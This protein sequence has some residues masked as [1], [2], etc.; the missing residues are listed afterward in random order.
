MTDK[1]KYEVTQADR[2]AANAFWTSQAARII[3]GDKT[4]G[5]R[6]GDNNALIQLL[7]RH[8]LTSQPA[9]SDI[10]EARPW[11]HMLSE[12]T[13]WPDSELVHLCLAPPPGE[14]GGE[15]VVAS[16]LGQLRRSVATPTA[17]QPDRDGVLDGLR[18]V[19]S[20]LTPGRIEAADIDGMAFKVQAAIEALATTTDQSAQSDAIAEAVAAEQERCARIIETKFGHLAW[21]QDQADAIRNTTDTESGS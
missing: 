15:K 5:E 7:A 11:A 17:P 2:D 13:D 19:Y 14:H 6:D 12:F 1:T 20:N 18:D 4:L 9:H 16:T 21:S 8:R 10:M 3:A